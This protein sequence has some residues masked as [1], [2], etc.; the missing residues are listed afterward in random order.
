MATGSPKG[1]A[2]THSI[3]DGFPTLPNLPRMHRVHQK[4]YDRVLIDL[5]SVVI[6]DVERRLS[7]R[8]APGQRIAIGV[9]SRGVANI[10][11]IARATA[12]A[13]RRVGGDPFIVPAMGSHGGATAEGQVEI[14]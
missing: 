11:R 3:A 5:D 14:L 1:G 4:L 13:I 8:V 2:V 10:A 9:G 12:E 7:S 6:K